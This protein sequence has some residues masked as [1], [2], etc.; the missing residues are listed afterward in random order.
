GAARDCDDAQPLFTAV[1]SD[2]DRYRV[3]AGVGDDHEHLAAAQVL[4][5]GERAAI[6]LEALDAGDP[7]GLPRCERWIEEKIHGGEAARTEGRIDCGQHRMHATEEV[8]DPPVLERTGEQSGGVFKWPGARGVVAEQRDHRISVLIDGSHES[9][10]RKA[11]VRARVMRWSAVVARSSA[12][13]RV[14]PLSSAIRAL[15]SA[16]R[17]PWST[18]VL[19]DGDWKS[20]PVP[21]TCTGAV[22]STPRRFS[23]DTPV[24]T[25]SSAVVCTSRRATGSASS[26]ALRTVGAR[27]AILRTGSPDE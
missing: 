7:G 20:P 24:A 9:S 12:P 4:E 5:R 13:R 2:L 6:A 21:A 23:A 10:S 26:A 8:E 11:E 22:R 1:L 25:R 15:G 27:A 18:S 14:S 3:D 17:S 19:S 16:L